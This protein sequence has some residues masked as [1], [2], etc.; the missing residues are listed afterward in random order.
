MRE[1]GAAGWL[2]LWRRRHGVRRPRRHHRHARRLPA[3]RNARETLAVSRTSRWPCRGSARARSRSRGTHE[4]KTRYLPRVAQRRRPSRRSRCPNLKPAR[5]SRRMALSAREDGD[6]YVLDGDKTWISNGG[7]ADFYVVFARTGEAP[8]ARGISA[9]IVDADT[10]GLRNRRTH[11]RDRAASA[12]ASA[13]RRRT[14]AAQPDARRTRRR[15]QARDAHA[16]YFPHVGGGGVA[17]LRT[18]CDGRRSRR[19]PRRARCSARRSATF[20]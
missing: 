17:G 6:A 7:I 11:R 4:Q 12:R 1:L 14:R 8:G 20:S 10:P 13:L 15:F 5:T 16:G 9:F 18:A 3:A 19:A 2:K